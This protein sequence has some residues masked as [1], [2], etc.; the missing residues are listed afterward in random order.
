MVGKDKSVTLYIYLNGCKVNMLER[1]FLNL[2]EVCVKCKNHLFF[3]L[4]NTERQKSGNWSGI[5]R[6]WKLL[7]I[8]P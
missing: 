5:F 3:F 6:T 8:L 4:F 7:I 2:Q 1:I